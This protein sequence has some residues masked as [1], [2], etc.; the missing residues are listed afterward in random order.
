MNTLKI[1]LIP[2]T[3]VLA[4]LLVTIQACTDGKSEGTSIPK[5]TES[6]PVKVMSPE[7]TDS[8]EIVLTSGQL[9]T[10]DE[11]ILSFKTGGVVHL[12]KAE[13]GDRIRKGQLLASL[14][15]TEINTTVAQARL[16]FEKAQRDYLRTQNLYRDSV[17]T[18]EQLQN[19]QTALNLAREQADAVAF[20]KSHSEIY[21]PTDGYVLRKFVNPGYVISPGDPILM[22]NGAGKGNWIL[23]VGVSDKQWA[24]I[25]IKD[26][27]EIRIDAIPNKVFQGEVI[28]KSG[29]SDPG[30]GAFAVEVRLQSTDVKLASGMFGSAKIHSTEVS[31]AW[32][33]P[34]EAV[35]DAN[36]DTGYVFITEDNRK[37]KRCKVT[38]E[39]FDSEKIYISR[40]LENAKAVIVS[41]SA[42]LTENS[43]IYIIK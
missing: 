37:A 1:N 17:A 13:E 33:L 19:A 31:S 26:K 24:S 29:T 20:N 28:R 43:P 38:I 21:A 9:T 3:I 27:A 41:G 6:V 25:K 22:T 14:D 32:A 10:D 12:V 36:D 7:K 11:T 18:L 23:K 39:S 34:Y 30:T 16:G 8:N 40:G 5:G 2:T 35:L 4:T 42:Y 15:L